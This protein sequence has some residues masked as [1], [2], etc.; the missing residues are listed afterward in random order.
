MDSVITMEKNIYI[1]SESNGSKNSRRLKDHQLIKNNQKDIV[2]S[3]HADLVKLNNI[4][5]K[6]LLEE[7][8]L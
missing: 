8:L 1:D 7:V 3:N 5:R 2:E 6:K 4:E